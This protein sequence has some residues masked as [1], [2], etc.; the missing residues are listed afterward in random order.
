MTRTRIV[1]IAAVL[2]AGAVLAARSRETFAVAPTG[3]PGARPTIQAIDHPSLQA[4]IDALPAEGGL[5]VLPPGTFEIDK[6][7]RI[8]RGDVLLRGAGTATHI[9]N[10]NT[11]G[12][13][14]ITIGPRDYATNKQA[15]IWRVALA[16][17]RLTGNPQ[18]GHG[19]EALGVNEIYVNGL[20]IS[21]NGGDGIFLD[22]CYEDPRITANILSYNKKSGL[23]AL[24]VHDAVV[25]ANH[26]EENL[27]AVRFINSFNLSMSGNN[28]DDHLGDCVII[29]QTYGSFVSS[30]MIEECQG[31]AVILDRNCYGI[32][33]SANVIA[34]DGGGV[35][36][37][38]AHGIAISAN[39]FTL[40][41]E[42]AVR[43]GPKSGRIT[44]SGNNFSNAYVGADAGDWRK[45]KAPASGVVLEGTTD[46]AITGNVFSGLSTPAVSRV[47]AKSRGIL[48]SGN[49]FVDNK[50]DPG[51][52][53]QTR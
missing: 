10:L 32:T 39:T 3:L 45:G 37:R 11:A 5:V 43:I 16:D 26:F 42:H 15:K 41:K 44:V 25:A 17:F 13:S 14:A 34:H 1:V 19:I 20:T 4:A 53:T 36:L 51:K 2:G 27:N 48:L 7:L 12:A 40:V 18:S 24:G 47:G 46:V 29:E 52:L 21:E 6:P 22:N 50:S 49:L 38:D 31:A 30:N 28:I 33:I 35:H 23:T 9:K 8:E